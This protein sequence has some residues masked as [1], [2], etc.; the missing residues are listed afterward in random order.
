LGVLLST[1]TFTSS[2]IKDALLEDV[3]PANLLF[4]MG[5]VHVA[6]GIKIHC[7]MQRP[8]YILQCTPPSSIFTKS[9]IS[10][11]FSLLQMFGCILGPWS[12]DSLKRPRVCK[13]TSFLITFSGVEFILTSTIAPTTYLGNWTFVIS[14]IAIRC[15]LDQHPFLLEALTWI[16]NNN[17]L[18]NNTLRRHV[19]F[20]HPQ[21]CVFSSI[22]TTHYITNGSTSKFHLGA[23]APSYP[24]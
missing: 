7:F 15:M 21:A 11:D 16:N 20:Y 5:D 14:V 6:F 10:F 18:S 3:Q 23:F 12:F 22:W 8:S 1:L 2:F 13:Q 19:I 4:K 9:L 24:F 17:F